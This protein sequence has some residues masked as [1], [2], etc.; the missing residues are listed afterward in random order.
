MCSSEAETCSII[1][2]DGN[3]KVLCLTTKCIPVFDL[4]QHNVTVIFGLTFVRDR[5]ME[6]EL[7]TLSLSLSLSLCQS[8]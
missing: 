1:S 4:S 3:S 8:L 6:F 7:H 5:L 2:T